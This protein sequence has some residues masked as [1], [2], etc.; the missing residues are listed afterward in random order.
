LAMAIRIVAQIPIF[1]FVLAISD[2]GAQ[3]PN[4]VEPSS[5][6]IEGEYEVKLD[7]RKNFALDRRNRHDLMISSVSTKS[8]NYGGLIVTTTG[9][10]F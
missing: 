6:D 4:N 1:C 9:F 2:V 7:Y 5:W 3:Q 8:F 10:H